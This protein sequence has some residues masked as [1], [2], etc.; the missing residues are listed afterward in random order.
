M[1]SGGMKSSSLAKTGAQNG[2]FCSLKLMCIKCSKGAPNGGY[3]AC[4][5]L[6]GQHRP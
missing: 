3:F 4:P 5:G 2:L 6:C 1:L